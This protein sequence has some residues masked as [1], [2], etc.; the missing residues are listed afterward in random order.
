M[1]FIGGGSNNSLEG[2]CMK[3]FST[4]VTPEYVNVIVASD[5][6]ETGMSNLMVA[7]YCDI[8]TSPKGESCIGLFPH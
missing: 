4:P 3:L 1:C 2:Y 6:V 7:T 5:G 8:V